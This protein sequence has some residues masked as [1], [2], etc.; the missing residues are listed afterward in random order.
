MATIQTN[1]L[2]RLRFATI[3]DAQKLTTVTAPDF[4]LAGPQRTGS[5]WLYNV[6]RE[7]PEIYLSSPKELYY[8]NVLDKPDHF[9]HETTDLGWYLDHFRGAGDRVYGEATASY[10]TMDE[11]LVEEAIALVPDL[12]VVITVRHPIDRLWS[13]AK[14]EFARILPDV[15]FD[16]ISDLQLREFGESPYHQHCGAYSEIIQMWSRHL[17]P[18]NLYVG[19]FD[20][21]SRRPLNFALDV[22]RFLGVSD[23]PCH[24]EHRIEHNPNPTPR[25]TRF[26]EQ[27]RPALEDLYRDEIAW[28]RAHFNVPW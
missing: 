11:W 3:T 19:L 16:D 5:T 12:R 24:I 26:P 21:I 23:D 22:A 13:H 4:F 1:S 10:A 7:H 14:M 2:D 28:L 9:Q 6:L 17:R 8:W 18:G 25:E 27:F 20:D 15:E